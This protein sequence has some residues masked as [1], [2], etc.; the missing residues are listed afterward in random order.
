MNYDFFF[1]GF[2]SLQ[3]NLNEYP[4]VSGGKF[5]VEPLNFF[6]IGT[7]NWITGSDLIYT[8]RISTFTYDYSQSVVGLHKENSMNFPTPLSYSIGGLQLFNGHTHSDTGVTLFGDAGDD[9]ISGGLY[10]D[11]LS[12]GSGKDFIWAGTGNDLVDG[13]AED[14]LHFYQD[15]DYKQAA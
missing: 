1:F 2:K 5:L 14:D 15:I 7:D 13:G 12:G 8:S 4:S 11:E 3:E 9:A 10:S 6:Q